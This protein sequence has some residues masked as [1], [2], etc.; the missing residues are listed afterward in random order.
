MPMDGHL[1]NWKLPRYLEILDS[2]GVNNRIA[3]FGSHLQLL[4]EKRLTDAQQFLNLVYSG[5]RRHFP[6]DAII[7]LVN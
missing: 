2:S 1:A 5:S 7:F 6:L 3:H 4:S